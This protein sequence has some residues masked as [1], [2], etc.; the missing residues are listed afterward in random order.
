VTILPNGYKEELFH[1]IDTEK[2]RKFLGLPADKKI[3]LSVGNLQEVKGHKYLVEAMEHV[4]K[5]R[6]DVICLIV[7]S[8]K[9]E[10]MLKK[11]IKLAGLFDYVKLVGAKPHSEIPL[12]MNACDL[13]V[14]PSLRESFGVVQIEA[15]GCGK[16]VVA[17]YNG[18]S[19]EI[20]TSEAYGLLCKPGNSKNLAEGILAGIENKY[21]QNKLINY[22]KSYSYDNIYKEIY[23]IY[24]ALLGNNE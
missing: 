17:T 15:M 13:F 23:S 12:W 4:V 2:C 18:G 14:L 20:I 6:K 7:G 21:D 24:K 5:K 1:P 22:A 19:E 10:I 9:L 11:Q 3:V 8:G 16:P